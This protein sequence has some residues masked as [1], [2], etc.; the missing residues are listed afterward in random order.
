MT[1]MSSEVVALQY[2]NMDGSFQ[3]IQYISTLPSD[4]TEN[5]QG[6]AIHISSDGHLSTLPIVD[7]IALPYTV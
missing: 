6:S 2:N 7:M 1:E 4:F 3:I 5:S